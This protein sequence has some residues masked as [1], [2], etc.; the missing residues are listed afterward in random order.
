MIR[1]FTCFI[2]FIFNFGLPLIHSLCNA[3]PVGGSGR[4][5]AFAMTNDCDINDINKNIEY[6]TIE[7]VTL[8]RNIDNLFLT[9]LAEAGEVGYQ[10]AV[11]KWNNKKEMYSHRQEQ[12]YQEKST[13]TRNI[14]N[15]NDGMRM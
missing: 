6:S 11:S 3:P 5:Y 7:D 9:A 15:D 13:R 8:Q 10:K 2:Y 12:I 1:Y 4:Q 14:V